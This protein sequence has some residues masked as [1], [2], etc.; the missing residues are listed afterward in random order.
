MSILS[1]LLAVTVL[2]YWWRAKHG[3]VDTLHLG[4]PN[5]T[6]VDFTTSGG[7]MG[8]MFWMNIA[9]PHV[10]TAASQPS[11]ATIITAI[12]RPHRFTEALGY[13]LVV[14]CLWGAIKVRNMLPRPP[15]RGNSKNETRMTKRR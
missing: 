12:A 11:Q 14:P 10:T 8:A 3:H 4:I 6:Q 7:P 13:F 2:V 5:S 1:L 15:G 9:E